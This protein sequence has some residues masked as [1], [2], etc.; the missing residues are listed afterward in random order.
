MLASVSGH[1]FV[2]LAGLTGIAVLVAGCRG[3]NG[4]SVASLT[5]SSPGANA[6]GRKTRPDPAAFAAC[7]TSHGFAAAVGS[8]SGRIQIAGV[9]VSAADPQSSQFQSAMPACRTY[10]PGGGPPELTPEQ[11][12]TWRAALA[13][14]AACIRRKG[15]P[16]FPGP[17]ADGQLPMSSL[18]SQGVFRTAAFQTAYA[19]CKSQLP[20]GR[21][22]PRISLP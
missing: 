11:K 22:F 17:D 8:G 6:A 14:F 7:M 3:S 10:L 15:V 2:L 9:N 18:V 4:P 1:A 20:S 5:T 12:A 19:A 16:S 13:R 21:D